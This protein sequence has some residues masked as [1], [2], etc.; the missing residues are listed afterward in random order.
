MQPFVHFAL[1]L[2]K[3]GFSEVEED[4]MKW[5]FGKKE[6]FFLMIFGGFSWGLLHCLRTK[7]YLYDALVVDFT[8]ESSF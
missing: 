2:V 7:S 5:V 6:K 8:V 3:I 4:Q 1:D